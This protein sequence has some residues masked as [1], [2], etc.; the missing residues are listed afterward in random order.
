MEKVAAVFTVFFEEPF[1][2]GVYQRQEGN[3][4]EAAR[5]VFGSEPKDYEVQAF[6][7]QNWRRLRFGKTKGEKINAERKNPKRMQREARKQMS[8]KG[9][10]TKAQQALAALREEMKTERKVRTKEEKLA[11]AERKF[12]QRQAKRREKH[13]GH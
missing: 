10:G 2:C 9:V 12:Q 7:L 1:W 11:E 13:K 6:L 3:R 4:L 5:V 8:E